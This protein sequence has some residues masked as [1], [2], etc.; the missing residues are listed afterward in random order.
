M[1]SGIGGI[2]LQTHF[3]HGFL[4]HGRRSHISRGGVGNTTPPCG[5][6]DVLSHIAPPRSGGVPFMYRGGQGRERKRRK[7]RGRRG[8]IGPLL[9]RQRLPLHKGRYNPAFRLRLG[10]LARHTLNRRQPGVKP[11]FPHSAFPP[12]RS[13]ASHWTQKIRWPH[14][15]AGGRRRF[16]LFNWLSR[17]GRKKEPVL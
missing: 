1:N 11:V 10:P 8:Y 5:I 16:N 14:A 3:L 17:K 6:R 4:C 2:C 9:K 15:G 7:E 13:L 12:T